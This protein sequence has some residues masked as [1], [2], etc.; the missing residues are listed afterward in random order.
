MDKNLLKHFNH[1]FYEKA[2]RITDEVKRMQIRK[3]DRIV[4]NYPI[5]GD[6]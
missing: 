2:D 4:G 5:N 6:S 1:P 3:A